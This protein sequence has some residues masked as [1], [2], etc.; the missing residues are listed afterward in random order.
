MTRRRRPIVP[1]MGC[2]RYFY[3]YRGVPAEGGDI[4]PERVR[5]LRL[6]LEQLLLDNQLRFSCSLTFN[7]PFDGQA[8][9]TFPNDPAERQRMFER[10][11]RRMGAQGEAAAQ[12]S[13]P[14]R[15]AD[16]AALEHQFLENH[17]QILA[18]LGICSLSANPRNPL[19]WSHYADAHRG[20]C[21]QLDPSRDHRLATAME[22]DYSEEYPIIANVTERSD[23]E[24]AIRAVTRKSLDWEYEQ[25]W[26][27]FELGHANVNRSIKPEAMTALV[28]GLRCVDEP[29]DYV[30]GLLAERERRYGCC[31]T[32]Y[33]AQMSGG[34]YEYRLI[35]VR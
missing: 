8:R 11:G 14:S 15:T 35:R 5:Q 7:D 26:R 21:I 3:K 18:Q 24:G 16:Q 20:F 12:W 28:L 30:L 1:S 19:M 6:R 34:R 4:S 22:V 23:M 17:Q 33:Q 9:Y 13:H 32:V 10:F 25:E 27:M 31:P 29:R 2:P